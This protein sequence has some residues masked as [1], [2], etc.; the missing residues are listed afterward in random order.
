[1]RR[2]I[3]HTKLLFDQLGDPAAGPD[4]TT[5]AV[6]FGALVEQ[7]HQP[8]ALGRGEQRCWARRGGVTQGS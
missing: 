4:I 1:M 3:A 6:G 5:K 8:G 7:L 2:M